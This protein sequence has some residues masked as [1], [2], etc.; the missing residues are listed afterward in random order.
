MRGSMWTKWDLHLH[1]P[2]TNLN[3]QFKTSIED[4]AKK[5]IEHDIALAGITNYFFFQQE[6]L[7]KIRGALSKLNSDTTILGNLEFRITQ[8][9]K[10][11][12]WI[13]VHLVFS[14]RFTT[15]QINSVL[16]NLK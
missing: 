13:N 10:D 8:P 14:E 9:N 7:E 6:E 2:L 16:E 1:S 3:N 4:Y 5:L 15:R 11:G 12:E